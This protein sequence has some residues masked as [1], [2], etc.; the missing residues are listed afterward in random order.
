MNNLKTNIAG[1][2]AKNGNSI[3]KLRRYLVTYDLTFS[4][5]FS[6]LKHAAGCLEDTQKIP[7]CGN[8]EFRSEKFTVVISFTTRRIDEVLPKIATALAFC[9]SV[10]IVE[11][12]SVEESR[13]NRYVRLFNHENGEKM[14]G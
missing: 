8:F 5:H 9:P 2:K 6:F 1:V 12:V 3:P 7:G 10:E 4:K 11:P 13:K 14:E